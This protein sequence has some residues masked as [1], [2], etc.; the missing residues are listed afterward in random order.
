MAN[1]VQ[2]RVHNSR[3]TRASQP[4]SQDGSGYSSH[5]RND[6]DAR[7]ARAELLR[8]TGSHSTM[9][10]QKMSNILLQG[11]GVDDADLRLLVSWLDGARTPQLLCLDLAENAIGDA[12]VDALCGCRALSQTRSLILSAN[13]ITDAGLE[14]LAA[15]LSPR[16]ALAGVRELNLRGNAC[17]DE[18]LQRLKA[19]AGGRVFVVPSAM[20]H[21]ASEASETE[22]PPRC[23]LCRVV[24]TCSGPM[25]KPDGLDASGRSLSP[26]GAARMRWQLLRLYFTA[27]GVVTW[28]QRATAR[29]REQR[30]EAADPAAA[31]ARKVEQLRAAAAGATA[32][33]ASRALQL[34][35]GDVKAALESLQRERVVAM[36]ARQLAALERSRSGVSSPTLAE[37]SGKLSP[38]LSPT[39]K[40]KM[41]TCPA[42]S[43]RVCSRLA[44]RHVRRLDA[45]TSFVRP[46]PVRETAR[47]H[48]EIVTSHAAAPRSPNPPIRSLQHGRVRLEHCEL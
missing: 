40:S 18:A 11:R 30:E 44:T 23:H 13:Q 42:N 9:A 1:L 39:A 10:V 37:G 36:A 43:R 3:N 24:A 33:D 22:D 41:T 26:R 21:E 6:S 16:G 25:R 46:R 27:S 19:A 12:G 31:H 45:L 32:E 2:N 7:H 28:W 4:G 38:K 29:A 34:A 17:S 48:A 47:A 15:A 5:C 20:R 35:G 14:K 8:K